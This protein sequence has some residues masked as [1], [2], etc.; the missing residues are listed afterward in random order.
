QKRRMRM[1]AT[2]R[3]KW[4]R[5]PECKA[6]L[7]T[8]LVTIWDDVASQIHGVASDTLGETK[9]GK[10]FIDKQ[11]W[12]WNEEV[13]RV[14]KEKKKAFKTWFQSRNDVDYQ[15][16][17]TLRSAAKRAVAAA[18][19]G[20]CDQ[21]YED[22]DTPE[23]A[24]KIYRLARHRSTQ[25]TGQVRQVK[26]DDHQV[27][28]DPP[29]ILS[30]W[31]DYF[32]RICNEEFLHPP[33]RSTDPILRPIPPI[34]TAEVEAAIKK[35]RNGKTTGPDDIP[36]EVWKIL[37]RQGADI[38]GSLFNRITEESAVPPI[39]ATSTTVPIWKG[40]GD[41]ME[42]SSYQPIHLLCHAM[43]FE[44][45][46]DVRLH[47]T[48]SVT[49]NQCGFVKGCGTTDGIHA[50]RLL[51]EKHQEKN[52]S[53]HMA[54]LDLEK[55]FDRVPHELIW[56][57]LRLH[58]VPKAYVQWVQLLYHKVTSVVRGLVGT[59]PPFA[60]NVGIHQGS[61]LSPL[62]FV[63][64]M[65]TATANLQAPHPWSLLYADDV[66]L[67]NEE[68]QELQHQMQ[69]WDEH[70]MRLNT[71]KTEYMECGPQTVGTTNISGED[72]KKVTQFKYFGSIISSDGDTLP[73]ARALV[74]AAWMKRR[75]VTGV[76]CDRQMPIRLQAKVYKTVIRPVAL[77]GSECWPATSRH[78]QALHVMKMRMIRWC[79]GLT[80]F[81][82][83]LNDDVMAPIMV[84]MR[85]GRLRWYGNVMRSG[86]H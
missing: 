84:K 80:R 32:S 5:L 35:M 37:G 81:D 31:S 68:R 38:L 13:Q 69:R 79:L 57:A 26:D 47:K 3:I 59:S 36:A 18:K 62:L 83:V 11:I 58:N 20:H 2:K 63:L 23:G 34:T 52:K 46:L 19:T 22:L 54:F 14:V 30:S 39:W 75:Q 25:D 71:K 8:S 48:V 67:A 6:Q 4:W 15:H 16:Y 74:N 7:A 41:V 24:N 78:K 77:Y 86:E 40:K 42:C 50:A 60:I 45:V 82:H 51:L 72:L 56:H 65:D 33:I 17:K 66:F 64:C 61:A 1:N 12:W 9:P 49:L 43:I 27:P 29:V 73:D 70:G 28:R 55:A 10:K 53:V 76:L 85:E 21:L 44:R